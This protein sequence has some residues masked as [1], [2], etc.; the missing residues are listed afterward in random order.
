MGRRSFTIRVNNVRRKPMLHFFGYLGL[1]VAG[2]AVG[3]WLRG[4]E[5]AESRKEVEKESG[6][7]Q[8]KQKTGESPGTP[9]SGKK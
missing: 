8:K 5:E 9:S 2:G 4:K 7:E 6:G 3:Y 1:A